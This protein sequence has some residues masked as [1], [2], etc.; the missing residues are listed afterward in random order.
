MT[1]TK[2]QIEAI[3][4]ISSLEQLLASC[5]ARIESGEKPGP[6]NKEEALLVA[7]YQSL[8]DA[9]KQYK[10]ATK[11]L[12]GILFR[13]IAGR[14]MEFPAALLSAQNF[15]TFIV[16]KEKRIGTPEEAA[17]GSLIIMLSPGKDGRGVEISPN[18]KLR[19]C[20]GPE[21]YR[22]SPA[23]KKEVEDYFAR[24]ATCPPIEKAIMIGR[25]NEAIK[26]YS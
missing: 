26:L 7:I 14:E 22:M 15:S 5:M 8:S 17:Q 11:E 23:S 12:A 1:K 24:L 2:E 6:E 3:V 18:L 20:T 9:G 25:L 21:P 4:P 13:H 10:E 16:R 19:R